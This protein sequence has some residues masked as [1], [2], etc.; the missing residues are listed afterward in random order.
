MRPYRLEISAWLFR[1]PLFPIVWA[2]A[3]SAHI[4]TA[5]QFRTKRA[6][7]RAEQFPDHPLQT[8]AN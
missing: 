3:F 4:Q 8:T 2:W 1:L 5:L 7:S 6:D